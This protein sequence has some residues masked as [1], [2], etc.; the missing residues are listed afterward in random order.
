MGFPQLNVDDENERVNSMLYES[1]LTKHPSALNSFDQM[2]NSALG[3]KI[4]VFL[5]YDGTLSNIV[6]NPDL[7]YMTPQMQKT[8]KKVVQC[9]PTAIISGRG[10]EKVRDFVELDNV[11][12]AGSHGLD[13]AA[14]LQSFKYG[15]PKHQTRVLD[16]MGNEIVLFQPAKKYLPEIQKL[17][18]TL[19]EK[20]KD[21]NGVLIENNTFCV[22]VHFRH[23]NDEDY[24]TLENLV[25]SV[26]KEYQCFRM[27][28]G[29]MVFEIRPN[30]EWNKGHALNY[31]LDTLGFG[32]S[33]E[34]IPLYI[35]DDRT[36][37]DAFKAIRIRGEG[38][39][40]IVSSSPRETKALY[41]LKNPSEV[42]KF[43]SRLVRWYSIKFSEK[44]S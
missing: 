43:L 5:D 6:D 19:D 42:N 41:S 18:V 30:M 26:V 44:S 20:T 3:R 34:F 39:P 38:F 35:G 32:N 1:W 37:E 13:I 8:L 22:S 40:I 2:L 9:F 10:R 11:W 33:D 36:D 31:F 25:K 27:A 14:P 15:D 7:A 28:K 24:S 12:Y 4:V 17:L 16:K 21:I 23:V 29:K